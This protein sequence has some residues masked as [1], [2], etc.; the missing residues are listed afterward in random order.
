MLVQLQVMVTYCQ[1]TNMTLPPCVYDKRKQGP[2][3]HVNN[4]KQ[5][6]MEKYKPNPA[7]HG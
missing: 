4:D 2:S 3:H 5:R 6:L 7:M 1:N